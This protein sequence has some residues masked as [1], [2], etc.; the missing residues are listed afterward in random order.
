[1]KQLLL[2]GLSC[3][4]ALASAGQFSISWYKIAA[5]GGTGTNQTFAVTGTAGANDAGSSMNGGNYS[6]TGGFW[7]IYAVSSPG[8]P[9]LNIAVTLTNTLI[10][11]WPSPSTGFGLQQNSDLTGTVWVTPSETMNDDGIHRFIVV[12]P[13][14]GNR[15]Y[16]LQHP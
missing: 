5:G 13:S 12:I 2:I 7:A 8:A 9:A 11:S 15:F 10:I 1:M 6:V 16:R 4:C 14:P 3:S